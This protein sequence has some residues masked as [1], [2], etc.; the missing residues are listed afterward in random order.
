MNESIKYAVHLL[1]FVSCAHTKDVYYQI[2]DC[3]VYSG[4]NQAIFAI[5]SQLVQLLINHTDMISGN[6]GVNCF[7]FE[8]PIY[9]LVNLLYHQTHPIV[10][11]IK[12]QENIGA[13]HT[14]F[15]SIPCLC[16]KGYNGGYLYHKLTRCLP[17]HC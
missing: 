15:I 12:W 14:V 3:S 5:A 9:T 13:R 16:V 17:T 11:L 1:Y 4:W 7:K 8:K 10:N 2:N 6:F